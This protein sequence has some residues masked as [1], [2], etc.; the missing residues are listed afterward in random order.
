[1]TVSSDETYSSAVNY[2]G[3]P[4]QLTVEGAKTYFTRVSQ[5]YAMCQ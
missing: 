2:R 3:F 4:R 5:P 1:V